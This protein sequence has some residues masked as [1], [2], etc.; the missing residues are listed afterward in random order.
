M[1]RSLLLSAAALVALPAAAQDVAITNAKLVI[2]DGSAPIE[3]GTVV[4]RD[5]R[6]VEIDPM[7]KFRA[8]KAER[9]IDLA[10]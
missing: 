9:V 4:V 6:I 7:S 8:D 1:I 3:R 2:G 5:G 10:G